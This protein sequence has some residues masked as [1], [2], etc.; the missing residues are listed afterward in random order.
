MSEITPPVRPAREEMSLDALQE[1]SRSM[2]AL[3]LLQPILLRKIETGYE[4]EAGHRRFLA[5]EM[6]GWH[7]IEAIILDA[8]E[9]AQEHIERAHEN[10]IREQLNIV[11]EAKQ[12]KEIV[13]WQNRGVEATADILKKSVDW[14]EKRLEVLNFPDNIIQ[15][16]RERTL[17]LAQARELSK[18]RDHLLLDS[19]LSSVLS[20]GAAARTIKDWVHNP[21]IEEQIKVHNAM[22]EA[23]S[24]TPIHGGTLTLQCHLCQKPTELAKTKHIWLCPGCMIDTAS[25]RMIIQQDNAKAEKEDEEKYDHER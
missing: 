1:L 3:G 5:A 2:K 13:Y 6:I 17:N 22:S 18:C 24:L 9:N 20:T 15:C 8:S 16:L 4:I 14:I 23:L 7:K 21:E 11:E 10:L 25:L 12:V 19:L